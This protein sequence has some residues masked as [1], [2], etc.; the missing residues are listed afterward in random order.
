[1]KHT[2]YML[3]PSIM[4]VMYPRMTLNQLRNMRQTS[5][6]WNQYM[7]KPCEDEL[8][9]A[10]RTQKCEYPYIYEPNHPLTT[11]QAQILCQALRQSYA[12]NPS[13]IH[14]RVKDS[15]VGKFI[16]FAKQSKAMQCL[17][18]HYTVWISIDA[19]SEELSIVQKN[20]IIKV[21]E[22]ALLFL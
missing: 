20:E 12:H 14:I 16:T 1:M 19:I 4:D 9:D 11:I 21:Y 2:K 18:S 5:S 3:K 8:K 10:D 6:A 13:P 7:K 15:D 22:E 17:F